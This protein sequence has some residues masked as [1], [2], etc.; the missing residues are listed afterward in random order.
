MVQ[1]PSQHA[2]R[3]DPVRIA[4]ITG[5]LLLNA[6]ALALLL[7]PLSRPQLAGLADEAPTLT[8][9][10]IVPRP[11]PPAP[12]PPQPIDVDLVRPRPAT[13]VA[14]PRPVAVAP[15]AVAPIASDPPLPM[16]ALADVADAATE[17]FATA[18]VAA[19]SGPATGVQLAYA[20]ATPPPYPGAAIRGQLEGT[21]L[22]QVL[23]DIDGRPI[24]VH[25]HRSSGHRVLDEAARRHVLRQW[26]FQPAVR[27]GEPVQALGL[28]PVDFRLD[29]Q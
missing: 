19:E 8:M 10:W 22:L 23:V 1:Q 4:G 17:A 12:P 21:V 26:R 2:C 20:Q 6:C 27:N 16:P 7:V 29:R 5:T 14:P 15:P 9:D 25:V 18:P 28:V 11:K 13:P 3:P 24:E